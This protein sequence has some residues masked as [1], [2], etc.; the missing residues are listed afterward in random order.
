MYYVYSWQN[1]EAH[2]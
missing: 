1:K 2:F